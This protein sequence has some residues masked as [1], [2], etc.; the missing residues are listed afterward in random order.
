MARDDSPP[1]LGAGADSGLETASVPRAGSAGSSPA[2]AS[3]SVGDVVAYPPLPW[4]PPLR[5][6]G[7]GGRG[8]VVLG[9]GAAV[10]FHVIGEVLISQ[11]CF[12]VAAGDLVTM[13][14]YGPRA[15]G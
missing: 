6:Y 14:A 15:E 3:S 7:A 12:R 5:R 13:Q 4:H 2:P 10:T 8:T 1:E 11:W 9:R